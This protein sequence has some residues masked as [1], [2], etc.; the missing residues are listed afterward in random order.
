[1]FRH[2]QLVKFLG[3]EYSDRQIAGNDIK[4]ISKIF[5]NQN[6][7]S[8]ISDI[9]N[10]ED[11]L[12]KVANRSY[13]HALGFYK[14][15]LVDTQKDLD[16]DMPKVQ[17]RLH[18]WHPENQSLTITESLYEHSFNFVSKILTGKLENQRFSIEPLIEKEELLL[19]RLLEN[20]KFLSDE[21]L[22]KVE[23]NFEK[24]LISKLNELGSIQEKESIDY[25]FLENILYLKKDELV[26]V[27]DFY[28]YYLSDR[29]SGERKSYKHVLDRY[30]K[31]KVQDV[32]K[33]QSGDTYFHHY[34][35]PHRLSYDGSEINST[36][37]VT[38]NVP[39]NAKGGSFQR[40]SYEKSG[41]KNY[42]KIAFDKYKLKGTLENFLMHL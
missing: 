14:I 36:I 1:M 7:K 42:D 37:L 34:T 38:T 10:N 16:K 29:V 31:L 3:S 35:N 41:A 32:L 5:D 24:I 13:L 22:L 15:V 33:L 28:G 20:I 2:E 39:E 26:C 19:N 40:P 27:S 9:I 30:L 12:E 23:T 18:I 8:L 21:E 25:D 11:I 17:A 4:T 6:V